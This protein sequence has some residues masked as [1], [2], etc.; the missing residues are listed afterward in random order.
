MLASDIL[1]RVTD[2]LNDAGYTRWTEAEVLR[3]MSDGQREIAMKLPRAVAKTSVVQMAANDTRQSIPADGSS[4][5]RVSR[6]MGSDGATP[7]NDITLADR[8]TLSKFNPGRHSAVGSTVIKHYLYEADDNPYEF[9]VEPRTHATTPVYAE[10]VYAQI[11][12][13]LTTNTDTLTVI[14]TYSNALVEYTTYRTLDKETEYG[15]PDGRAAA[16]LG[17]FYAALG[18]SG[19][20]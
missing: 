17:R 6:N 7:G 12:A 4:L 2:Q 13:E 16:H 20:N 14:D 19:S 3:Y 10:L 9:E 1:S 18:V 15:G 8:E 11:P 5:I